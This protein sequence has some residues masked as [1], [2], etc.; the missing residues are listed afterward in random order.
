MIP[1]LDLKRV[2]S[3]YE[4]VFQDNFKAFLDSGYYVLGDK[5]KAFESAFASYCGTDHCIGV[6]NG[7]DALRLILEGYKQL[8]RLKENDEVLIASNTYIAT[9]LAVLQA[10]LKPVLVETN[11][12]DYNFDIE[13]LKAAITPTAKVIMPVHLYGQLSPMRAIKDIAEQHG[14]LIIEDAAQAHGARTNSGQRAGNLGDAAGFS[15]YPT[16]NLGALGDGGA[17][18]T[19]DVQLA[20]VI[21]SLANYGTTSKYVNALKGFNSRLDELQAAFLLEK[22]KDLDDINRARQQMAQFY[23]VHIKNDKISL[24]HYAGGKDHVFHLF[25]VRV[26]DRD[27]FVTHLEKKGIGTLIHYPI[28]PHKQEALAEYK[29]LRFPVCEQLNKEVISLP[30]FPGLSDD[31][32]LTIVNTI[33]SY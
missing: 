27:S 31:E 2:N 20:A 18:T 25:V 12:K 3:K 26:K 11:P 4:A 7:L 22:L 30:L 32:L 21:R 1:F 6:G 28:P 17:V 15:F 19:N 16:K 14:L 13:A 23:L 10:G 33:N 8:G 9:V 5:V 24:P 29:A